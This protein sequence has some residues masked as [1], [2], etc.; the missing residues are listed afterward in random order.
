MNNLNFDNIKQNITLNIHI[1]TLSDRASKGIYDDLS[2][3][4]I[5]EYLEKFFS[6][7]N[8][9]CKFEY[10]VIPDEKNILKEKL[11]FALNNNADII[12]TTGGTGVGPRDI[13]P[14]IVKPMI[15]KEI[16][17]IMELIRVKYG[18]IIP[19]AVLSRGVAG[20]IGKTQVYTLPGSLNAVK[21]YLNEISK[22]LEHLIFM[23]YNIDTHKKDK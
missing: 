8:W 10:F 16:P 5:L 1:L 9:K 4:F 2:G 7:K 15:D 19:N 11:N 13:T 23:Y 21:D 20:F 3:K 17:G 12:F 18:L 14:D 22:T 6:D